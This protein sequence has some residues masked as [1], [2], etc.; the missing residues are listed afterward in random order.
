[1]KIKNNVATLLLVASFGTTF[2]YGDCRDTINGC[3]IEQLVVLGSSA[4]TN[5]QDRIN[6]YTMAIEKIN[7]KIKE[8][9]TTSMPSSG[10]TETSKQSCIDLKN[11]LVLGKS[12][13][14]TG[15]E[16]SALQKYLI[17]GGYLPV[18]KPTGYYGSATAKA[19][20]PKA[21]KW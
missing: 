12:D 3:T 18:A 6:A 11:N 14:E 17:D 7:L 16:V 4:P 13:I 15:G 5:N 9:S 20:S 8:L 1:M 21:I 10:I 2:A 19:V